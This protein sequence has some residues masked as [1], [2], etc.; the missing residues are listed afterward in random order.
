MKKS[1]KKLSFNSLRDEMISKPEEELNQIPYNVLLNNAVRGL[2]KHLNAF[3]GI[4]ETLEIREIEKDKFLRDVLEKWFGAEKDY[5]NI[6][7]AHKLIDSFQDAQ[8]VMDDI[9][10]IIPVFIKE[11]NERVLTTTEA[12]YYLFDKYVGEDNSKKRKEDTVKRAITTLLKRADSTRLIPTAEKMGNRTKI[13][14]SDIDHW[15]ER[16]GNTYTPH[17][18]S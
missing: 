11:E 5:G 1:S 10:K 8:R 14:K 17:P 3:S 7:E 9:I 4:Y 13:Y 2:K 16:H 12:G 6:F 18:I 15:F